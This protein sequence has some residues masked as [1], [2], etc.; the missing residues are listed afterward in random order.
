MPHIVLNDEQTKILESSAGNVELRDRTG[1]HLGLVV[2]GFTAEEIEIAKQRSRS[3][4]P[5]FTTAQV[6][7]HLRALE[8]K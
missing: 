6:L 8:T 4:A 5:C 3:S 2:H 7:D 1:R